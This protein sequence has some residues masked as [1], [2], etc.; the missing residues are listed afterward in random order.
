MSPRIGP[1]MT[2]S[3]PSTRINSKSWK[4]CSGWRPTSTRSCRSTPRSRRASL[5]RVRTSLLAHAVHLVRRNHR[6]AEWRCAEHSRLV[7]PLYG[8]CRDP[9]RG[10]FR[11]DRDARWPF[12]RLWLLRAERPSPCSCAILSI[13]RG[14][15]GKDPMRSRRAG[16]R[17][18]SISNMTAL[19]WTRSH[20][21]MSTALAAAARVCSRSTARKWLA[22]P[23]S[24]RFRSFGNG[25]KT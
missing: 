18:S 24:A 16:T 7:I 13:F 8:R 9:A 23:W 2:M 3:P 11:D 10:S 20:S 15:D 17:W 21:T 19:A 1:S 14:H 5:R 12:W 25:T 22:K 4:S 6:D